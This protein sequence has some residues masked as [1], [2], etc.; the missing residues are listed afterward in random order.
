MPGVFLFY[1]GA[2]KKNILLFRAVIYKNIYIFAK[3]LVK[4]VVKRISIT[5]IFI[6][7][8]LLLAYSVIPH[9]HHHGMP[10]FVMS[11]MHQHDDEEDCSHNREERQT[12]LFEQNIDAVYEQSEQNCQNASCVLHHP[13]MFLFEAVFSIF[14]YNFSLIRETVTLLEPPFLISYYCEYRS[15]GQGLRAPPA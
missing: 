9:H 5:F 3:E 2:I 6:A 12:C 11:E 4:T 1:Q 8:L 7:N 15:S 10:H 13:E 14:S